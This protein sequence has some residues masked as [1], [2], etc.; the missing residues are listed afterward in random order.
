MPEKIMGVAWYYEQQWD[1]VRSYSKDRASMPKTFAEWLKSA[2]EAVQKWESAGIT[3]HKVYVDVDMLVA[4]AKKH[5][6]DIDGR[7]RSD[8]ANHLLAMSFG[9]NKDV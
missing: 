9:V 7:T 8:Y 4:W 3:V 5:R 6:L 2:Q 1:K